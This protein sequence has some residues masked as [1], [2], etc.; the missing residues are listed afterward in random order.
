[1]KNGDVE[2]RALGFQVSRGN[3]KTQ[4]VKDGIDELVIK[5]KLASHVRGPGIQQDRAVL[6]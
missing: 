6:M 1:M 4:Q 3:R 5:K 2:G